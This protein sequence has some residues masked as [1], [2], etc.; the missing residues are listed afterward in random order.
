VTLFH[1]LPGARVSLIK[2]ELDVLCRRKPFDVAV[3]GLYSL[4]RGVAFRLESPQL[5]A[6]RHELASE[7]REWLTPQDAQR[8][9]PHVTIQNKVDPKEARR[10]L[11]KLEGS[12]RSF[13]ARGEGLLLW[14][15]LGGPWARLRQFPFS[16]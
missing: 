16:R 1:A 6:L 11:S 4:G 13:T 3:T 12:F 10:L 8:F 5:Q 7:W 15:Y 2:K 14:R 9:K